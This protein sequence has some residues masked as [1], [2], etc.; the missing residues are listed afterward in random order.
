[1][2]FNKKHLLIL[3]SCVVLMFLVSSGLQKLSDSSVYRN[4]DREIRLEA[5]I[6]DEIIALKNPKHYEEDLSIDQKKAIA[7]SMGYIYPDY[8][9]MLQDDS[10]LYRGYFVSAEDYK[11]KLGSYGLK[12][13]EKIRIEKNYKTRLPIEHR[14][15]RPLFPKVDQQ[16]PPNLFVV[17]KGGNIMQ[18]FLIDGR[19]ADFS[20]AE[21]ELHIRAPLRIRIDEEGDARVFKDT[22]TKEFTVEED[23]ADE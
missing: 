2:K 14:I 18:Y 17:A 3:I 4:L 15:F 19:L 21:G 10:N 13:I 8:W 23:P 9:L 22:E 11:E 16:L 6:V 7:E 1:M 20:E 12:N 5:D